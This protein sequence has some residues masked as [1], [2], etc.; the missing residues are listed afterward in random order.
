[1]TTKDVLEG[2][3]TL[4]HADKIQKARD[5]IKR[6]TEAQVG[7]SNDSELSDADRD[8]LLSIVVRRQDEVVRKMIE[9]VPVFI[10]GLPKKPLARH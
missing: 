9:V 3:R 7:I 8:A 4:F 1:M 6:L 2:N 10:A 5:S